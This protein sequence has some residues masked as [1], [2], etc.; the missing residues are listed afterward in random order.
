MVLD[1]QADELEHKAP[2]PAV[3]RARACLSVD[4]IIRIGAAPY[5]R[6]ETGYELHRLFS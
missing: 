6:V 1:F 4:A 2:Y 3:G 5:R